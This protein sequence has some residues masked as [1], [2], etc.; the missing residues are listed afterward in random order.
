[1]NTGR[2]R[3]APRLKLSLAGTAQ[4]LGITE[5]EVTKLCTTNPRFPRSII[6]SGSPLW[7]ADELDLWRGTNWLRR[8]QAFC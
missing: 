8:G 3:Y 5:A 7:W 6:V 1:M 4:Y 2:T